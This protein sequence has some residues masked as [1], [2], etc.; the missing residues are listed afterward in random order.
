LNSSQK[1][2][3]IVMYV[4]YQLYVSTFPNYVIIR[5]VTVVRWT[6]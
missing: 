2:I 5:L 6:I 3:Y 1:H 4:T